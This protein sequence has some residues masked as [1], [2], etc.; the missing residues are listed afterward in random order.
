MLAFVMEMMDFEEMDI[1]EESEAVVDILQ[2]MEM[3]L[4]GSCITIGLEITTEIIEDMAGSFEEGFM[5]GFDGFG[6]GNGEKD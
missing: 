5:E 4:D 3:E 1:P 6:S 2:S